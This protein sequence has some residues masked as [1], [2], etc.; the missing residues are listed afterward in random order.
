[1]ESLQKR[2]PIDKLTRKEAFK[3][4]KPAREE[5]IEP[6]PQTN[7][8]VKL[9]VKRFK[10]DVALVSAEAIEEA[11]NCRL[12]SVLER[13][14]NPH[15]EHQPANIILSWLNKK[16]GIRSDTKGGTKKSVGGLLN[17]IIID[18]EVEVTK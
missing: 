7:M 2:F 5:V 16:Q 14:A 10:D 18:E 13:D 8:A 1:L 6:T 11:A 3:N 12:G 4:A 15:S 9:G 17:K